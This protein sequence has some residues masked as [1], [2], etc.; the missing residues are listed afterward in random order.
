MRYPNTIGIFLSAITIAAML[1]VDRLQFG[2]GEFWIWVVGIVW[3]NILIAQRRFSVYVYLV[4]A[5]GCMGWHLFSLPTGPPTSETQ[6]GSPWLL[7][8]CNSHLA[9]MIT[10]FVIRLLSGGSRSSSGYGYGQY[11]GI[12]S[13]SGNYRPTV[14]SGI[15]NEGLYREGANAHG[16]N[17][18]G[19][20]KPMG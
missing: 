6:T 19:L 2:G 20:G 12:D 17:A 9:G 1:Q 5:V 4:V 14:G 10:A 18:S 11:R 3:T 16:A 7:L 8:A 13:S 15:Y